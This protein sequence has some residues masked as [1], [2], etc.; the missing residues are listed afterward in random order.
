MNVLLQRE[1]DRQNRRDELLVRT[2]L[3][4]WVSE[5]EPVVAYRNGKII[6]LT[7]ASAEVGCYPPIFDPLGLASET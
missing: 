2:M 7:L 5:L 1:I 4:H 3:E 6:G